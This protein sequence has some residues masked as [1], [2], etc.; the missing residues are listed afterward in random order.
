MHLTVLTNMYPDRS[1]PWYGIFV[2]RMV[3]GVERNGL[4]ATVIAPQ[5]STKF[6]IIKYLLF[7]MDAIRRLVSDPK[8]CIWVHYI[9]HCAFPVLVAR[10]LNQNIRIVSNV[11][12]SDVASE[13][14]TPHWLA[15]AKVYM[16]KKLLDAS[17]TVIVPSTYYRDLVSERYEIC[18]TKIVVSPSG[19]VNLE[20]FHVPGR[21]DGNEQVRIGYV[22]RLAEDKGILDFIWVA[23]ELS[24]R[25]PEVQFEIT[26]SG[27]LKEELEELPESIRYLGAKD[28]AGVA[29]AMQRLDILLFP[30]KRVSES[31][32]LVGLEAMA[33]GVPVIS[34]DG[35]GPASYIVDGE[36]G[37]LVT[38]GDKAALLDK[39]EH[40]LS[41]DAR[42]RRGM[43][44]SCVRTAE[45]YDS[46]KVME[47]LSRMFEAGISQGG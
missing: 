5:N 21:H 20:R 26:G 2:H 11:H 1:L 18:K 7:Y 12:G 9:S 24:N 30:T 28:E 29:S 6:A 47:E 36:N 31:L 10:K 8:D 44:D 13:S 37:Y 16:S 19:G 42:A 4:S 43:A 15:R 35:T 25:K 32:G 14:G 3:K 33:C 46:E 27:P 23:T 40:F 22:G 38:M 17:E 45:K 41:L 39:V 34:Y